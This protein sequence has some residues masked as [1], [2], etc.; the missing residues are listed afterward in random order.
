M[1]LGGETLDQTGIATPEEYGVFVLDEDSLFGLLARR[2]GFGSSDAWLHQPVQPISWPPSGPAPKEKKR[3][4]ARSTPAT[5]PQAPG[6]TW[7]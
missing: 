7:I 6:S 1:S 3:W 4:F 2:T 5:E